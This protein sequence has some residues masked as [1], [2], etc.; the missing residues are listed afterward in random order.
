MVLVLYER[1]TPEQL[2]EML[3][4]FGS[5]IKRAVDI[6][7]NILAGGGSQHADGEFVLLESGSNNDNIWGADWDPYKQEVRYEAFLNIRPMLGNRSMMITNP[8][9][10]RKIAY[11]CAEL[12][13][14]LSP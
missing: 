2:R 13:E 1:A 3:Q 9:I 5:F 6:E 12:L 4:V 10:R 8:E 14:G 11:V 7:R